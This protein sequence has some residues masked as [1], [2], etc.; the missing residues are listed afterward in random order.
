MLPLLVVQGVNLRHRQS[1][2]PCA[3]DLDTRQ[4]TDQRRSLIGHITYKARNGGAQLV[5]GWP[6]KNKERPGQAP[7]ALEAAP[8]ADVVVIILRG[9]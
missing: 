6:M 2:K 5:V 4:A 7:G 1:T 3:A 9:G 8:P